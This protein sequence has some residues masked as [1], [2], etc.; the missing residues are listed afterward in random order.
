MY[1]CGVKGNTGLNS[2][3]GK[4]LY[5]RGMRHKQKY[6]VNLAVFN[7]ERFGEIRAFLDEHNEP[8]FS[9]VDICKILNLGNASQVKT[10][11][12][13]AGVI[14]NEV[15]VQTGMKS[16]GSPAYMRINMNFV[17]EPNLYRCIFKSRKKEAEQFQDW[18][19]EEVIPSI[20]KNGEY[21]LQ[22]QVPKTFAEALRLAAEQQEEIERQKALIMEQKPKVDFYDDV[23]DSKDA[24]PMAIVA[25]TLNMGIGRNKLFAFL[26]GRKVLRENNEP[27]QS[28]VDDGWFRCVESKFTKPNGDVCVNIKTVVL[29]KGLDGIRRLLKQNNYVGK[30]R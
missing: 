28:Y 19:F 8:W 22:R 21:N 18:I 15:G 25:K 24:L 1:I 29:Q 13:E 23:V 10:T 14:T 2:C 17:N 20:R 6:M 30:F 7:N 12:K 9:L 3:I 5:I 27:Y 26:R 16:D 4:L 11:L